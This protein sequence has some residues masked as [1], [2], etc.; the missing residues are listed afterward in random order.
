VEELRKRG[1]G[2]AATLAERLWGARR[3]RFVGRESELELVR[4]ALAASEPPFAVLFVHGPGGVGKSA[5]LRAAADVAQELGVP[6]AD[7]DLRAVEPSPAGFCRALGD[8]LGLAGEDVHAGRLGGGRRLIA[9]DTYERAGALDGWLRDVFLPA[10]P[11]GALVLIAGREAPAAGWMT[12]PGWRDLLR[13]VSLRNLPPEDG[14]ALLRAAGVPGDREDA[15][16]AMTHG[17]PLAL[18]LLVDVLAQHADGAPAGL[19]EAPDVVRA[20]LERFADDVP[21]PRHRRALDVCAQARATTEDLLRSAVGVEDAGALFAWLRTLSFLED[22]PRGVFPHDLARDVLA[23]DGRWRDPAG[24]D[25]LHQRIHDHV[26]ERLEGPGGDRREI[27]ADLIFLHRDNPFTARFWDWRIFGEAY[28]DALRP[29]DREAV[30]AMATRHEGPESAALVAHWLDRQPGGFVVFRGAAGTPIGFLGAIALHEAAP[31][32]L[33]ADPGASAMWAATQRAAPLRPGEEAHAGRFFMDDAAYQGVASPSLNMVTVVSTQ[34][35][36]AR[37][38]PAWELIAWAQPDEVAG[39][40]TYIGFE[41]M[42][43]ADYVVGGRRYGAYAHDWRRMGVEAWLEMMGTRE[44][45]SDFDPSDREPAVPVLALSQAEFGDAVRQALR[46]VHRPDALAASP[47]ARSRMVRDRG[48]DAP[49]EQVLEALLREAVATLRAN[50][51]DA[52]LERALDRT[53][54]RPAPTQERAAELLGLPFSTYRRHLARGI[55]RVVAR[56]WD[57]EVYGR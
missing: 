11:S 37:R 40:M 56:L 39:L 57:R 8:R 13:V 50:P 9:L 32:D 31:E 28:A 27:V 43:E 25:A 45:A 53:F 54:L 26:V 10:I 14:R 22:G 38:R 47:L 5:L 1:D 6:A 41:R 7:V 21:S 17:H 16:L 35:W 4:T 33:A 2:P 23:A 34:D 46:D 18:S 44:I 36:L 51:R 29:A 24:Y 49:P 52:K 42:P 55:E 19:A 3:R 15:L 30:L 20:L 48:D 12:D